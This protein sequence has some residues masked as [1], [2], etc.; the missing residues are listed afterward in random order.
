[1]RPLCQPYQEGLRY[2]GRWHEEVTSIL[3]EN[4]LVLIFN[5]NP[6]EDS[7]CQTWRHN[8]QP[9]SLVLFQCAD[10]PPRL[11]TWNMR[12]TRSG[13]AEWCSRKGQPLGA[14]NP[15]DPIAAPI[16]VYSPSLPGKPFSSLGSAVP[17]DFGGYNDGRPTSVKQQLRNKQQF[18]LYCLLV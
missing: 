3:K 1:M 17:S 9:E 5:I 10:E 15:R 6:L 18:N 4:E 8:V 7:W 11:L 14:Q 13:N 12:F 16:P 2:D